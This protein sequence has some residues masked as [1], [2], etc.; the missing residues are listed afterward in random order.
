MIVGPDATGSPP[1]ARFGKGECSTWNVEAV[2]EHQHWSWLAQPGSDAASLTDLDQR[3]WKHRE[4]PGIADGD[5]AGL[6]P[7]AVASSGG[8]IQHCRAFRARRH[9]F[10]RCLPDTRS[11][12]E[13]RL[14]AGATL[15]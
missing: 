14:E 7:D 13:P 8:E 6:A 1:N 12:W 4:L 15:D 10:V 9:W 3:E 5:A 2:S 11:S